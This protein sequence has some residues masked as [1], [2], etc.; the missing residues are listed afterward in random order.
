MRRIIPLLVVVAIVAMTFLP[1]FGQTSGLVSYWK[2]DMPDPGPIDSY[3]TNNLYVYR[4]I[5]G[6]SAGMQGNCVRCSG[7]Q[8]VYTD[9]PNNLYMDSPGFTVS[10]WAKV[11]YDAAYTGTTMILIS[12][13]DEYEIS[14]NRKDDGAGNPALSDIYFTVDATTITLTEVIT[15]ETWYHVVGQ[16]DTVEQRMALYLNGFEHAAIG[17]VTPVTKSSSE[18]DFYVCGRPEFYSS[19]RYLD[20][21]AY[22]RR[23]LTAPEII[24][25]FNEGS[26]RSGDDVITPT[27]QPTG[28][29]TSTPTTTPQPTWTPTATRTPTPTPTSVT[30]TPGPTS[31][32]RPTNTPT[33][34]PDGTPTDTPTATATPTPTTLPTLTPILTLTPFS[35]TASVAVQ[36]FQHQG[37][38]LTGVLPDFSAGFS[39]PGGWLWWAQTTINSFNRGNLLFVICGII[40][41]VVVIGYIIDQVKNPRL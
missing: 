29:A 22:W 35:Y 39:Q 25:L 12:R 13:D 7:T 1:A 18:N 33:P 37:P 24:W 31:T 15:F 8:H 4:G 38:S 30:A 2:L 6:A 26:G 40:L 20:E 11:S 23:I 3:G 21:L 27:L 10:M 19:Y 36:Q 16:Y 14:V 28:T 17:H 9:L 34:P 5:I 41:A 32:L